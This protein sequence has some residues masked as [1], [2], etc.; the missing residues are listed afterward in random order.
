M[1]IKNRIRKLEASGR[2]SGTCPE[3]KLRPQDTGY[4]VLEDKIAG[5][6]KDPAPELPEVCPECR[7]Y[8]R[9]RIVVVEEG[10]GVGS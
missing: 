3:C 10:E 8:T 9:T 4:I 5:E 7:R 6:V 1:S 2:G